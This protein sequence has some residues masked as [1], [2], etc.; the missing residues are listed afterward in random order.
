[1]L[2]VNQQTHHLLSYSEENIVQ[3]LASSSACLQFRSEEYILQASLHV[4]IETENSG[5]FSLF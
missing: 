3:F 5:L 1:M 4:H 2:R